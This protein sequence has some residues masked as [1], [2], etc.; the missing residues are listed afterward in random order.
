MRLKIILILN[1]NCITTS[2]NQP[3]HQRHVTTIVNKIRCLP[4]NLADFLLVYSANINN[5][6]EFAKV[7]N[8]KQFM[9]VVNVRFKLVV[10]S[11]V[12]HY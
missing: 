7:C 10:L 12:Q 6:Y 5:Y 8:F 3:M 2:T 1:R 4:F 9:V 11:G